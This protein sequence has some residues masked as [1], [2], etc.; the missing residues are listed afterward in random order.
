MIKRIL[1]AHDGSVYGDSALA[2]ALWLAERFDAALVVAHVV[3]IVALEGPFLHDVSGSL[4]FEPY[5]NFSAKM[6]EVLEE[7]GKGILGAATEAAAKAGVDCEAGLTFGIVANE[8]CEKAKLADLLVVGRRGVNAHYEYGLLGSVTEGV[9]RKSPKPVLIVP[10]HFKAPEKPMLAYDG[11]PNASKT[12]HSA[13]EWAKALALPLSVVTISRG[14]S[15]DPALEEARDYLKPYGLEASF[16]SVTG[17]VPLA[18]ETYYKD[19]GHDLLFIGTS[20]HS[21]IVEMVLGSTTEHILRAV[22]GP[23]FLER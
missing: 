22:Q 12:M 1:V 16:E 18:L 14:E 19:K 8:L 5:L 4:G 20:H 11:S 17:E 2:Y 10:E 15:V 13:A 3:D 9:I 7:R 21:R 6:R 23:F